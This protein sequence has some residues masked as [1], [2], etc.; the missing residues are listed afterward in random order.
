MPISPIRSGKDYLVT[1]P[2]AIGVS[3]GINE[4]FGSSLPANTQLLIWSVASSSF[5]V[6]LYDPTQGAGT[7]V[8]YEGDDATP[9]APL[10]EVPPGL[11]FFIVPASPITNTFAGAV[12]VNVGTS[13]VMTLSQGGKDYLVAP[14]VP[15]AGAIT[16]GNPVT[17]TGGPN[18]QG[19]PPNTQLLIWSTATSSYTV[20][21]YDPTQGA[22]TPLWYYGDDT[23][24]Y[25]DPS[26]GGNIPTIAVGQGF[27][28][29]PATPYSWTNG[30]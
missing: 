7:P 30:L 5:T 19:L 27:F 11:G 25:V 24:P 13:N 20:A 12:A 3:N 1:C 9:L 14:V 18:L 4:V 28:I 2:F 15:Y 29:V 26:T 22:G 17:G 10:P 23:T 16:N 6:A 21:L 8:W